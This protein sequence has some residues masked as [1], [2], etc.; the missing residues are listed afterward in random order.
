MEAQIL[1][2]PTFSDYPFSM[3]QLSPDGIATFH[4]ARDEIARA[5]RNDAV[6]LAPFVTMVTQSATVNHG[7]GL[8]KSR[9]RVYANPCHYAQSMFA[10][11]GEAAP[12]RTEPTCSSEKSPRVLPE[13]RS[14]EKEWTYR[15][16]DVLA[17]R[18]NDGSLLLS[19]VHKGT[20]TPAVLEITLNDVD[21]ARNAEI[22]TLV[23][24]VP[25]AVNAME[26]PEAIK[27]I[28]STREFADGRLSLPLPP[29]SYALVRIPR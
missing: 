13:L 5:I 6:R 2:S 10:A 25:W 26:A 22:R 29:Y 24:D 11:L 3:G 16:L 15:T 17:A 12:V 4:F 19:I 8:R 9:E 28:A 21:S 18:A 14:A 20:Q 23:A 7:G 27:P 1:R